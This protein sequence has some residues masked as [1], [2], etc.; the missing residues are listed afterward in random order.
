MQHLNLPLSGITI[1]ELEEQAQEVD[2]LTPRELGKLLDIAPQQVYGWIRKGVLVAERCQCGR[3]VVRVSRA[4]ATLQA[5]ARQRGEILDTRPDAPGDEG[6][7]PDLQDVPS[8]DQV[9]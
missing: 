8:E 3:T 2:Y 7:W 4:K 1:E 9:E 6:H 5:R